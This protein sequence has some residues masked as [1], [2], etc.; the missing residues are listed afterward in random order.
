MS[1]PTKDPGSHSKP[2]IQRG[3]CAREPFLQTPD[4]VSLILVGLMATVSQEESPGLFSC[5]HIPK[6]TIQ[7]FSTSIKLSPGPTET[8]GAFITELY[9]SRGR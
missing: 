9:N 5:H 1:S 3:C 7:R 4:T 8:I 2:V 6:G